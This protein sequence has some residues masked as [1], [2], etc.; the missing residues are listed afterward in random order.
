MSRTMVNEQAVTTQQPAASES[1]VAN[2]PATTPV[3]EADRARAAL[4]GAP[5]GRGATIEAEPQPQAEPE[6]RRHVR[7]RNPQPRPRFRPPQDLDFEF[8]HP[9]RIQLRNSNLP[10][11]LG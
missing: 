9:E 10:L 7:G 4:G 5:L 11:T 2:P 8:T 3:S 6:P 1:V